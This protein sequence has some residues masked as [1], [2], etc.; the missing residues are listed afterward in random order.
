[1]FNLDHFPCN[2]DNILKILIEKTI[3]LI[4]NK[5]VRSDVTKLLLKIIE[6]D[7][8]SN[9]K[10]MENNRATIKKMDI[11][12]DERNTCDI[13][14]IIK[15]FRQGVLNKEINLYSHIDI[16]ADNTIFPSAVIQERL[17]QNQLYY[18][19]QKVYNICIS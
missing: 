5:S 18:A 12:I 11:N 4:S 14:K 19:A 1:M 13:E 9:E 6:E 17:L 8:I 3:N 10:Y 15:S 16:N 7:F 2:F